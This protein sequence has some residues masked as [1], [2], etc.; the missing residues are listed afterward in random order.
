MR[1][2]PKVLEAEGSSSPNAL[3]KGRAWLKDTVGM[4][5]GQIKSLEEPFLSLKQVVSEEDATKSG[6]KRLPQSERV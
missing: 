2:E 5:S 3:E 1:A 4:K 6:Y